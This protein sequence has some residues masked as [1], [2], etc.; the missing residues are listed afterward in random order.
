MAGARYGLEIRAAAEAD[1]EGLSQLF[2]AA[3]LT[4]PATAAAE[5]LATARRLGGTVLIASAWGPPSGVIVLQW[6]AGLIEPRPLA[7]ITTLLVAP[8]ERRNGIG[9]LLLKA[10]AQAARSAGCGAIRLSV[11]EASP[12][13]EGFALESG[14]ARQGQTFTRPLR[15]G[16]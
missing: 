3:G 8:D 16:G 4:L 2:A 5:R 1:A 9:R 14:F 13:L 7:L 12:D 11:Q 15:K 6:A 10:G